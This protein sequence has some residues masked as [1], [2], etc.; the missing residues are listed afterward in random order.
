MRCAVLPLRQQKQLNGHDDHF[1][2]P[3]ALGYISLSPAPRR[4]PETCH[5]ELSGRQKAPSMPETHDPKRLQKNLHSQIPRWQISHFQMQ[6]LHSAYIDDLP[7]PSP[8]QQLQP[9]HS[10]FEIWTIAC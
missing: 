6:I 9:P 1:P 3:A 4:E 2:P 7:T 10:R 5:V 8:A